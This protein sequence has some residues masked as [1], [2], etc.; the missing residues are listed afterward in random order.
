MIHAT[1]YRVTFS[2]LEST[3]FCLILGDNEEYTADTFKLQSFSKNKIS[4]YFLLY[5]FYYYYS[6]NKR[7]KWINSYISRLTANVNIRYLSLFTII[8]SAI[9]SISSWNALKT[10][11]VSKDQINDLAWEAG[12]NE[13]A[14]LWHRSNPW[15][16]APSRSN[17]QKVWWY[18]ALKKERRKKYHWDQLVYNRN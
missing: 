7:R 2:G 5:Y 3:L 18:R 17:S 14:I 12:F 9:D 13:A 1:V 10:I 8:L 16:E 4:L 15:L 11:A 6:D